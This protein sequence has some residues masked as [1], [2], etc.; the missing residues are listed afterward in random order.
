MNFGVTAQTSTS[1]PC[2]LCHSTRNEF[3]ASVSA[4]QVIESSP[5]YDD[6]FYEAFGITPETRFALSRCLDCSLVFSSEIP[7][8]EVLQRLYRV[9][10]AS[11]EDMVGV[12]ARPGRAAFAFESLSKLLTALDRRLPRDAQGRVSDGVRI[13]DVGCAFGVGI[14]GLTREFFP[15]EVSGVEGSIVVRDY[16]TR[17]GVTTYARLDDIPCGSVFDGIILNDVLEHVPEPMIFAS[18]LLDFCHPG[19][20]LWINVPNFIDWR[21][22]AVVE[23]IAKGGQVPKDLNPW[24]HLS[25]FSPRTLD[26][27]MGRAG[28]KR[29]ELS[30][31]EYRLE[32]H[33]LA[34][35]V[36]TAIRALR[37][38]WRLYRKRYPGLVSTSGLFVPDATA[39]SRSL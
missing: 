20:V 21:M 22:D 11:V 25:Y 4:V 6:S 38:I 33:S 15:Y 26:A 18:R 16:L 2:P 1:R 32:C 29:L 10:T 28:F 19:S 24:E 5:Y 23:M 31:V 12:F 30:S 13:L 34:G 17:S 9:D 3:V 36:K 39:L 35:T 7:S 8:E 14:S 27:L 37:D